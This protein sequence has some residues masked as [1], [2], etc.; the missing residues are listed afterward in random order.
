MEVKKGS[1]YIPFGIA[2]IINIRH[3]LVKKGR[4]QKRNRAVNMDIVTE[5]LCLILHAPICGFGRLSSLSTDMVKLKKM[6]T[7]GKATW[8][9]RKRFCNTA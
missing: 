8:M 5:T 3:M 6:I 2:C 9:T 1:G 7:D 4:F